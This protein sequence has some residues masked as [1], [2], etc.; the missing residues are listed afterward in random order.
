[1]A[2]LQEAMPSADKKEE[3]KGLSVLQGNVIQ[4]L[5]MLRM[6]FE[7]DE[8]LVANEKYVAWIDDFAAEFKKIVKTNPEI[9]KMIHEGHEDEAVEIIREKLVAHSAE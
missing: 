8:L 1:M 6:G 3:V 7:E 4:A 5:L 9:R 2:N